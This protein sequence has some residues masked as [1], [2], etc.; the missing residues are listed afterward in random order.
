[1]SGRTWAA[2]IVVVVV[3]GAGAGYVG[4]LLATRSGQP[5]AQAPSPSPTPSAGIRRTPSQAATASPAQSTFPTVNPLHNAIVD[6]LHCKLPVYV[7]SQKGS[8]GFV[9]FPAGTITGDSS[10]NNPVMPNDADWFGLTYDTAV[11]HWLPVPSAW[12]APDGALYAFAFDVDSHAGYDAMFLVNALTGT[13]ANLG[14][15]P[16]GWQ[17][18]GVSSTNIYAAVLGGPGVYV[19]AITGPFNPMPI[20]DGYWTAASGFFIYGSATPDG[21]TIVQMDARN[22]THRVQWFNKG[23]SAEIIGFDGSGS[24]VIWTGTDLWIASAPDQAVRIGSV[25]P[26][27]TPIFSRAPLRGAVAPVADSHGLWF[28]TTDGIYIYAGGQTTK[29]SDLVAQVAGTCT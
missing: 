11:K 5:A 20:R 8:G 1:M 9:N 10:S 27:N 19:Q 16:T 14:Q 12:V 18:I 6:G 28:S 24:P 25:E 4:S 22:P 3:V 26:L 13:G 21:G 23:G 15:G 17:V 7:L 29:V 2:V